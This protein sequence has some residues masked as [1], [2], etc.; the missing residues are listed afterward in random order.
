VSGRVTGAACAAAGLALAYGGWRLIKSRELPPD[1]TGFEGVGLNRRGLA[2][3]AGYLAL[4]LGLIL[5]VLIA[6]LF[7]IGG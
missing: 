5:T 7:F 6:P 1:V 4:V 3:A 2:V